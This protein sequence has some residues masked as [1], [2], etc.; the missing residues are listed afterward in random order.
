LPARRSIALRA[1]RTDWL[2]CAPPLVVSTPA[3]GFQLPSS[4]PKATMICVQRVSARNGASAQSMTVRP[5]RGAYC[6][7]VSVPKRRPVP[8]AGMTS[9]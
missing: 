4:L 7:G 9:Q 6:F 1:A 3:G 5:S 2:R 8:A